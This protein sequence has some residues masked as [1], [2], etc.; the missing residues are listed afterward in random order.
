MA[1]GALSF[2][3][4][5][6]FAIAN[7]R[8]IQFTYDGGGVRVAEPHDYGIQGGAIRLNVYQLRG[9]SRTR[10]PDWRLL[11][12][13]KLGGLV[14]LEETFPGSRGGSHGHHRQWDVL[15]ARVT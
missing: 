15:F 2:D 5:L 4:E 9:E 6:R 1:E 3:E 11:F 8:L 7:K 14:V 13:S 10:L 12:A